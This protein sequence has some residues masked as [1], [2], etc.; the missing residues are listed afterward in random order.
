MT[1]LL[2]GLLG[3]DSPPTAPASPRQTGPSSGRHR[4][5]AGK[6]LSFTFY[7][8]DILL[9]YVKYQVRSQQGESWLLEPT[10]RLTFSFL[11]NSAYTTNSHKNKNRWYSFEGKQG[12]I[13]IMNY[14]LQ[15]RVINQTLTKINVK[16]PLSCVVG[17]ICGARK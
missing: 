2:L 17:K 10:T 6:E 12:R 3:E 5:F 8:W 9:R 7:R 15:C 13:Q 4:G 11:F 1:A 16:S 14:T